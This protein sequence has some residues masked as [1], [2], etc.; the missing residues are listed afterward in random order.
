MPPSIRRVVTAGAIAIALI[1][2]LV[3]GLL[4]IQ[5]LRPHVSRETA[6]TTAL[7]QLR[8]MNSSVIGYVLVGARYDPAPDLIL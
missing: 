8:Q 7:N 6:T 3:A 5:A 2:A 4:I 1:L